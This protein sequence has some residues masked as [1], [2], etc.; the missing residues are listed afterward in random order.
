MS[1]YDLSKV[2]INPQTGEEFERDGKKETIRDLILISLKLPAGEKEQIT[3]EQLMFRRKVIKKISKAEDLSAVS[4]KSKAIEL[5]KQK[6]L[7]YFIPGVSMQIF[8]VFDGE[9]SDAALEDI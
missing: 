2:A 3:E 6:A 1:T 5:I 4:L 7:A 8:E 9:I